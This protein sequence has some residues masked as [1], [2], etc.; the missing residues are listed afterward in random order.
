MPDRAPIP[1]MPSDV[2]ACVDAVAELGSPVFAVGGAVRD[3]L[4]GLPVDDFD[5][6]TAAHPSE[7]SD[8]LVS[9]G[10]SVDVDPGLGRVAT[11]AAG[12]EVVFTTFRREADYGRDRRPRV[13]AFV[14]SPEDDAARRDFTINAIYQDVSVGDLV[15]PVSG[16]CD[17]E[18]RVLRV[19]GAPRDRLAEDPLRVLRGV[20]FA[21]SRGLRICPVTY[22]AI[23]EAT[24]RVGALSGARRFEE[25]DQM[26]VGFGAARAVELLL[27]LGALGVLSPALRGQDSRVRAEL[28]PFLDGMG[29]RASG[30]ALRAAGFAV[31]FG[32]STSADAA[33]LEFGAPR[34]L[35]QQ[36]EAFLDV[37]SA[38]AS[39][40]SGMAAAR[41]LEGMGE[42]EREAL[43]LWDDVAPGGPERLRGLLSDLDSV[44]E[45]PTGAEVL[46]LGVPPGP[47]VGDVLRAV[48]S[49]VDAERAADQARI[50]DILV[51]EAAAWIKR[52]GPGGR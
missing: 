36:V 6:A 48:R 34:V 13:V 25:V 27:D 3:R 12:G 15:D 26:L 2:A 50:R 44:P 41:L 39:G 24:P 22:A 28:V 32:T 1:D 16:L 19:I 5:F 33:L 18:A 43:C 40:L 23:V 17:L 21:A 45:L 7:V 8:A 14:T 51:R 31:L 49:A 29:A 37:R 20:R 47:G 35:R 9:H 11:Q 38:L 52:R 46:A 10:R 4:L 30:E 42:V